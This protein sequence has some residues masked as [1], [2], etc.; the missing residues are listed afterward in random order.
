MFACLGAHFDYNVLESKS[1]KSLHSSPPSSIIQH[2][3]RLSYYPCHSC[4]P[5]KGQSRGILGCLQHDVP[6]CSEEIWLSHLLVDSSLY[7]SG[8]LVSH[9][10]VA[11]RGA[12][13]WN[14]AWRGKSSFLLKKPVGIRARPR[15]KRPRVSSS[16]NLLSA[17]FFFIKIC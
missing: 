17:L 10:A 1:R 3:L 15:R 11:V 16:P 4:F 6:G 12:P 8:W 7:I 13:Q 14:Q 5:P 2:V 9:E